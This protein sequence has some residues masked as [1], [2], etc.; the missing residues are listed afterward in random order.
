MTHCQQ[1]TRDDILE[2]VRGRKE[3]QLFL[4]DPNTAVLCVRALR[5]GGVRLSNSLGL[6]DGGPEGSTEGRTYLFLVYA[7]TPV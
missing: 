4:D 5:G 1:N 2:G 6:L 7:T 3:V